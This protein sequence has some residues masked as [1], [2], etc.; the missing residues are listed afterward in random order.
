MLRIYGKDLEINKLITFLLN[1]RN[2]QHKVNV[3]FP[4]S[5]IKD[6]YVKLYSL[7]LSEG[8]FRNEFKLQ[9]PE[10]EF[11][12]MFKVSLKNLFGD[13]LITKRVYNGVPFTMAPAKISHLLPIPKH[14]PKFILENKEFARIYLRIAFEAEGSLHLYKHKTGTHRR[15]KL[16]R[17]IGID[18]LVDKKLPYKEGIRVYR[19]ILKKEFPEPL[20]KITENPCSIILGEFYMLRKHF[21]VEARIDPEY[22]RINKTSHRRGKISVKWTLTIH[23]KNYQ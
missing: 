8:S 20:N 12:N 17:N 6:D 15:I 18:N 21:G 16:S 2:K 22:I 11:H 13:M 9:V 3:S 5:L 23:A 4:L 10:K 14:I 7:M 1:W 19:G